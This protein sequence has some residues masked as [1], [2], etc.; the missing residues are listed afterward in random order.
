MVVGMPVLSLLFTSLFNSSSNIEEYGRQRD[1]KKDSKMES[2]YKL[3]GGRFHDLKSKN[4]LIFW[5][6]V[7]AN[8][9]KK[10]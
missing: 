10:N 7:K 3:S 8:S 4:P 2:N 1:Q 5:C 6:Y 9:L